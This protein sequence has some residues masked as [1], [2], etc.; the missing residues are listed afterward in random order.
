MD[1][2]QTLTEIEA[3]EQQTPPPLYLTCR[4]IQ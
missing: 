1:L 4:A 2:Q 3:L